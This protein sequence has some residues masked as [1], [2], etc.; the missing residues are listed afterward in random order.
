MTIVCAPEE[1]V[2]HVRPVDSIGFGLGP[3]NPDAI[4]TALGSR[5]DWE[6]LQLGGALCLNFY[7]VFTKP[8]VMYR[9]GSPNS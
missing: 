3:A 2:A 8:G 6:D 7:D 1:A 5:D 9:C 4:L